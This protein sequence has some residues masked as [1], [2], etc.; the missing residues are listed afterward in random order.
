[1]PKVLGLLPLGYRL[2]RSSVKTEFLHDPDHLRKFFT[3][4]LQNYFTKEGT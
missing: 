1:M 3:G 4:G 2:S